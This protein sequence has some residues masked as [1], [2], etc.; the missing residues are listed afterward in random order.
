MLTPYTQTLNKNITDMKIIAIDPGYDRCGMA[1]LEKKHGKETLLK[2]TCITTD[3][4]KTFEERLLYVCSEFASCIKTYKP[5]LCVFENL[6]FTTNQKTAMR[7][8]EVRGALLLTAIKSNV[9]IHEFTPKQIKIAVTGDGS[10]TKQQVML[11][12]PKI[13]EINKTIKYDDEYDAIATA[14]TASASLSSI[15]NKDNYPQKR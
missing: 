15:L 1:V 12:L 3:R 2:S 14:L 9:Q 13:I 8:S 10:A 11:M 4:K 7:V 6:F 5:N